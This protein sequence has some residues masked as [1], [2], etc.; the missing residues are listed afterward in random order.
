[1]STKLGF[2]RYKTLVYNGQS[3]I[4]WES[5]PGVYNYYPDEAI[6]PNA[7][8]A[9]IVFTNDPEND[10]KTQIYIKEPYNNAAYRRY[11]TY[12]VT[13]PPRYIGYDEL[14]QSYMYYEESEIDEVVNRLDEFNKLKQ[15]NTLV[16][17]SDMDV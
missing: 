6:Y 11:F 1:M 9:C 12:R 13:S 8:S 17:G 7:N 5:G 14:E 16:F 15:T 4:Y 2:N 3:W 10:V